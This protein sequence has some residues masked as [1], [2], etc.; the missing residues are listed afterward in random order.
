MSDAVVRIFHQNLTADVLVGFEFGGKKQ[1][2]STSKLELR[3]L[4]TRKR[5]YQYRN[6]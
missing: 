3:F 2:S 4:Y 5:N 6:D 1:A